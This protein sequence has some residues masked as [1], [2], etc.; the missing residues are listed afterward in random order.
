MHTRIKVEE[1]LLSNVLERVVN[2][3]IFNYEKVDAPSMMGYV[4]VTT[5][6]VRRLLGYERGDL[7]PD[8]FVNF[9]CRT[10][11]TWIDE[12]LGNAG[13]ALP[14]SPAVSNR[15]AAFRTIRVNPT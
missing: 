8:I 10:P 11:I 9:F 7:E 2:Y 3:L 6:A 1:P 4:E 5:Q 13:K 14:Q 15:A 12:Y